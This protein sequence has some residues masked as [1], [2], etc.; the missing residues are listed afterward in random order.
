MNKTIVKIFALLLVIVLLAVPVFAG[1]DQPNL[2]EE[3]EQ[4]AVLTENTGDQARAA[5]CDRC[6][7]GYVQ[8]LRTDYGNEYFIGTIPY[9]HATGATDLSDKVYTYSITKVYQC[10]YCGVQCPIEEDDG[11]SYRSP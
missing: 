3:H 4:E 6:L 8:Y 1:G 7:K 2:P 5:M 11:V 10:T 9:C